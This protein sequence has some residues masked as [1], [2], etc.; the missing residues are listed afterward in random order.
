MEDEEGGRGANTAVFTLALVVVSVLVGSF[1]VY[2]GFLSEP[3][4]NITAPIQG[5]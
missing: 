5:R 4:I 1:L 3:D 2:G